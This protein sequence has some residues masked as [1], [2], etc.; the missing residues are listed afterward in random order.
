MMHDDMLTYLVTPRSAPERILSVCC[1][2]IHLQ[3]GGS[4]DDTGD[5]STSSTSLSWCSSAGVDGNGG[6]GLWLAIGDC[7]MLEAGS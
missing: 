1:R 4:T 7:N 2:E 5:Q 6:G 3:K